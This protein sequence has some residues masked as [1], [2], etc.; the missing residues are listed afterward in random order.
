MKPEIPATVAGRTGH[1]QL[2][3]FFF[4]QQR[5]DPG[6]VDQQRWRGFQ[7]HAAIESPEAADAVGFAPATDHV[8]C[9]GN[10]AR[11]VNGY[12]ESASPLS[13]IDV[14][15]ALYED[16]TSRASAFL[17]PEKVSERLTHSAI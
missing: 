10:S 14:L 15:D 13:G 16:D 6:V 12:V 8:V 4:V 7:F 3:G 1:S 11:P 2:R 5:L 9:P 17:R